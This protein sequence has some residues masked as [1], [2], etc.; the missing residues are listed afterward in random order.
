MDLVILVVG[1]VLHR[2]QAAMEIKE[3]DFAGEGER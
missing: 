3:R 1:G 2:Q